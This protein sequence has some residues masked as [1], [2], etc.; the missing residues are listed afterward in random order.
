MVR[1]EG[2]APLCVAVAGRRRLRADPPVAVLEDLLRGSEHADDDEDHVKH[3]CRSESHCDGISDNGSVGF[4]G[5][6]F[7]QKEEKRWKGCWNAS[8]MNDGNK[9]R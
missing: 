3:L 9:S 8:T 5:F 6:E 1:Q 7:E 4:E 2:P